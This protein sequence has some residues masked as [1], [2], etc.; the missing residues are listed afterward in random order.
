MELVAKTME[1]ISKEDLD[2]LISMY[3][4]D[5]IT[6]E[7]LIDCIIEKQKRLAVSSLC[8]PED[9]QVV[10]EV[11]LRRMQNAGIEISI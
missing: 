3:S 10:V 5:Q 6:H 9:G 7:A 8:S 2:Q 4:K 1:F 11:L